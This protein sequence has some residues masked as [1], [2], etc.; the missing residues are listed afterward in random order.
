M[1]VIVMRKG[2]AVKLAVTV[3]ALGAMTLLQ[4][5][6]GE[7]DSS[8]LSAAYTPC[9]YPWIMWN[10]AGFSSAGGSGQGASGATSGGS[11]VASAIS[12]GT[13]SAGGQVGGGAGF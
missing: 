5:C 6:D 2:L 11:S 9:G 8:V 3:A 10:Y 12:S 4:G 1:L 13:S 7:E